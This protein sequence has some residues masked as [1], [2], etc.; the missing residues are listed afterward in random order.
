MLDCNRILP[1]SLLPDAGQTG[2]ARFHFWPRSPAIRRG[3][4]TDT[5]PSLHRPR[6][7]ASIRQTMKNAEETMQM[8]ITP[9]LL[10]AALLLGG[11]EGNSMQLIG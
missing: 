10:L 1:E 3:I 6:R 8:P 9:T 5:S 2:A 4:D 11:C 7:G